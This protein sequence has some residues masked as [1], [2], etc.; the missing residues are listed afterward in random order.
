MAWNS[1]ARTKAVR[2]V[3]L[4]ETDP[5]NYPAAMSQY[6]KESLAGEAR[7]AEMRKN[8]KLKTR[9]AKKSKIIQKRP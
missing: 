3:R 6:E 1:M 2:R 9:A 4:L 8:G 7:L 5:L